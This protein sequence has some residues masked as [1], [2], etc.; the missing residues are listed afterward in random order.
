MTGGEQM[1]FWMQHGV[2]T[3]LLEKPKPIK[4]VNPGPL[5]VPQIALALAWLAWA[6]RRQ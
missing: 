6:T 5:P 1:L 3:P 4:M 2:E